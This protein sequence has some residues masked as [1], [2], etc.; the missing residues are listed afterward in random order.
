MPVGSIHFCDDGSAY[1]RSLLEDIEDAGFRLVSFERPD[2]LAESLDEDCVAVVMAN[3]SKRQARAARE[4]MR[5]VG[6]FASRTPLIAAIGDAE[7][8]SEVGTLRYFDDLVVEPASSGE[9]FARVRL[10]EARRGRGGRVIEHGELVIDLDARRVTVNSWT[11]DL[12]Y[13]EYELLKTI[14]STPGRAYSREEL[15]RTIWGY[16]YFGGTRTVDVHIRRL[17]SKV[18]ARGASIETVHGVGYRFTAR[19]PQAPTA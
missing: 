2:D 9:L 15:L 10:I 4:A 18:D 11:V 6:G 17:R 7:S 1:S 19:G 8:M 13:K 3:P 12:T 5:A 14:A 16:D